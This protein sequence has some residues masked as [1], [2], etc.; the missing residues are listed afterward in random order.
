MQKLRAFPD[1]AP[2]KTG[3][4]ETEFHLLLIAGSAECGAGGAS[5]DGGGESAAGG[6]LQ[7]SWNDSPLA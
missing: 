5:A 7:S 6:A 1:A 4:C 2:T 3:A